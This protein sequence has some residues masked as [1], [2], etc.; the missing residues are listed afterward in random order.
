MLAPKRCT[1]FGTEKFSSQSLLLV[2]MFLIGVEHQ[3]KNN[4][5]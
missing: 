4:S 3:V 1:V 5:D 2:E